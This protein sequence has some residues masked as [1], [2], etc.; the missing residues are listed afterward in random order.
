[1][2]LS[3]GRTF[4]IELMPDNSVRIT[5]QYA[6]RYE[7]AIAYDDMLTMARD[8]SLTVRFQLGEVFEDGSPTQK[9]PPSG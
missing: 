7:A 6:S 5:M 8:G 3:G 1:M 4:E 2:K 9:S